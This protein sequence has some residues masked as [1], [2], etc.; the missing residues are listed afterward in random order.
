[1][2]WTTRPCDAEAERDSARGPARAETARELALW[3]A[4][5]DA[6]RGDRA[7]RYC[8]ASDRQR[9]RVGLARIAATWLVWVNVLTR[10]DGA[11]ADMECA[12]AIV[13]L[14]S[15]VITTRGLTTLRPGYSQ[16][17]FAGFAP[18]S[19]DGR[20]SSNAAWPVSAREL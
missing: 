18:T 14:P 6:T 1:M 7:A 11:E 16:L 2:R 20:S 19:S 15:T 5:S 10:S 12:I 9:S 17:S 4:K 13:G 3:H 8:G